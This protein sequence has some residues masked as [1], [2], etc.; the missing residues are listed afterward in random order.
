MAQEEVKITFTIDGIEKEVKSVEELQKEMSNL[1]KETKKVAQENSILAKGKKAFD[2]MKTGIKGATAGFKGLKGAIAATGL[3]ALLI[4]LTSLFAYFKNSEE[5]S[6]KLAIAMEALSIITGKLMDFFADLGEKIVWAFT[7]PKEALMTFVNLIKDNIIT[8]FEGLLKLIPR[9]GEAISE[10][11]KGNF[12]NAGKIAADAVGQVVLGVEDI[13][14]KVADATTAVV[15]F[16]KTVVKEV[17]EAVAVATKLVDQFRAIRDE[18]Q[19]L[20]VDNALLNKEMETQQKIA[21]DTNR[22]YE[23]RKEALERVGEAQVKLAENLARQAKLEEDNLKLQISQESNYEKREE[24]ETSLA[25]ATAARIDAETALETRKLDASRITAELELQE[26]ERKKSINDMIAT[27]NTEAIDN[28][29]EKAYAELE[30]QQQAARDELNTYRATAE[31]KKKVDDL[32]AKKKEKLDKEKL[33]FNKKIQKAEKDQQVALAG[34]T[35]GAIADLLGENSAAGK[36]AAI[37]AATI[38]TYQGITTEL[39]TK[40]VTPFEIGLKIANIATIAAIGFKSVK[41]IISTPV[42]GG[43]GGTGGGGGGT[44]AAPTI[45]AF[46]P[47]EALNAAAEADTSEENI[48]TLGD[49]TAGNTQ[50]VIRAYVVS[51][52]MTSQQEADAKI[53]DLARL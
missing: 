41:D 37:A 35:F 17:K 16:G 27:L 4:A 9:L 18:Q 53:N 33:K 21:E 1:G 10:L 43:G 32:F 5:G 30:I 46:N 44:P 39:A 12:S 19:R 13:T 48:V 2:D 38:N 25:E 26:V 51:D 50:P 14:D 20:I 45:P 34:Q 8:R 23:E 42:P 28:Q 47:G 11:F 31:E 49:Q 22:T 52:E 36:A 15:E 29:W 7:S 24:L 3:G 6:R 40:T